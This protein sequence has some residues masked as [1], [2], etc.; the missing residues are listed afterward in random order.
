MPPS[1][2]S[3]DLMA[4]L[5]TRHHGNRYTIG[6]H[7]TSDNN[8]N[9]EGV[10]PLKLIDQNVT[11]TSCRISCHGDDDIITTNNDITFVYNCWMK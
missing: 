11:T 1:V 7:G 5:R 2:V 6:C 10:H 9:I 4:A 3:C 8:H